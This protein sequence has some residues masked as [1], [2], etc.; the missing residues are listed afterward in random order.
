MLQRR[1]IMLRSMKNS[2][3]AWQARSFQD[4]THPVET[5]EKSP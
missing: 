5:R 1:Q 3:A 2:A 4:L